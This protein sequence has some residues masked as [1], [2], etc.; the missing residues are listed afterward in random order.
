[1]YYDEKLSAYVLDIREFKKY[2]LD[3]LNSFKGKLII[4]APST[5]GMK[6]TD[7]IQ[8][9]NPN[10]SFH[11][12]GGYTK[13]KAD[14]WNKL[15]EKY[16][17]NCT[18]FLGKKGVSYYEDSNIYSI[19]EM[20]KIVAVMEN[21][22]SG[23]IS[24]WSDI[25]KVLYIYD[26]LREEIIYHPKNEKQTSYDIRTLRGL[27]SKKTVCAGYA[28]IFKEMLDR[29]GIQCDYVEGRIS[30]DGDKLPNHAWNIVTIDGRDI[31]IDLTW[32]STQYRQ[33]N[34]EHLINFAYVERFKQSHFP[35][36]LEKKQNYDNLYGIKERFVK[37]TINGFKN[38]KNYTQSIFT[39]FTADNKFIDV[40]QVGSSTIGDS[41]EK[42]YRYVVAERDSNNNHIN[43]KMVYSRSSFLSIVGEYQK[44]M[45]S[46]DSEK[47]K[48]L[49]KIFSSS[50]LTECLSKG[51][52][53]IGDIK[54]DPT[55]KDGFIIA[56]NEQL[57]RMY[58]VNFRNC[59]RSDGSHF[60]VA[61]SKRRS[62]RNQKVLH[63]GA[64]AE[65][66]ANSRSLTEYQ[67]AS[68]K[69]FLRISDKNYRN[70]VEQFL[71]P[72]RLERKVKE[73]SGYIGSCSDSGVITS[74]AELI[75][76]FNVKDPG[77]INKED[78]VNPGSAENRS[79]IGLFDLDRLESIVRN[80][81]LDFDIDKPNEFFIKHRKTGQEV[82]DPKKR[83]VAA[84]ANVWLG[85][86]GVKG[87]GADDFS[88]INYAFND[89]SHLVY[90][91]L[92]TRCMNM[93]E[94][95]GTI[96]FSKLNDTEMIAAGYSKY[97]HAYEIMHKCIDFPV[98]RQI[99]QDFFN[100]QVETY[101][102]VEAKRKAFRHMN[103]N[104][105]VNGYVGRKTAGSVQTTHSTSVSSNVDS[106]SD[107]NELSKM[108]S[109]YDSISVSR[110]DSI[111][112]VS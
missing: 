58:P 70:F 97:K 69:S 53:Y 87:Y 20:K 66:N 57:S 79:C 19:S 37:Q 78:F 1:M 94:N 98:S 74:D 36:K 89:G 7:F 56:R 60:L 111:K 11:I 101:K 40:A 84:F 50:Y 32:D 35:Y 48:A 63:R 77:N 72:A 106:H 38:K 61:E 73:S 107:A 24:S 51:S 23:I 71:N 85:A 15:D 86:A 47:V 4:E 83:I 59:I 88:R 14:Y 65:F 41:K 2:S 102:D 49:K 109:E 6:S 26:R 25:K 10:I 105:I 64:V 67:V 46:R 103:N 104:P 62:V 9:T 100:L 95:S 34:R 93:L 12:R 18:G 68:E 54:N 55:S 44:G 13:E 17:R 28:L 52:N 29:Q 99:M 39:I 30:N 82:T 3:Y 27:I 92:Q 112:K 110:N 108:M 76:Q 31:P 21:I 45:L 22:E 8:F 91:F 80:Y 5:R 96:D 16:V 42:M 33:G 43:Y 81:T 90:D 75:R